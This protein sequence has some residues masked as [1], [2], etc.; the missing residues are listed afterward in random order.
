MIQ[1]IYR[2]TQEFAYLCDI[3]YECFQIE[4]L[5]PVWIFILVIQNDRAVAVVDLVHATFQFRANMLRIDCWFWAPLVDGFHQ[6]V[7]ALDLDAWRRT[8][9]FKKDKN[10]TVGV[11]FVGRD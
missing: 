1:A 10:V 11:A 7:H 3:I 5:W 4:M 8:S 2:F 9:V 6:A